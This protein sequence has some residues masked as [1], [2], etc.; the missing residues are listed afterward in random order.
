MDVR[1][2]L[3]LERDNITSRTQGHLNNCGQGFEA[4]ENELATYE[5]NSAVLLTKGSN[6]VQFMNT[7]L[8]LRNQIL[9]AKQNDLLTTLGAASAKD[10][11]SIY[12]ITV[13]TLVFFSF[14]FVA[15]SRTHC[16][17]TCLF[18]N[19]NTIPTDCNGHALLLSGREKTPPLV[20][21]NMDLSRSILAAYVVLYRLL[22]MESRGQTASTKGQPKWG[23]N[24][25]EG[26]PRI[27]A[28]SHSLRDEKTH[29]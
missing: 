24:G 18:T 4:E 6:A 19:A 15:V 22:E 25:V 23:T 28:S 16:T 10:S 9:S 1:R 2:I 17:S 26:Q 27:D 14:A 5:C 3:Y 13:I 21:T 7:T 29:N 20:L 8:N 12:V 11:A